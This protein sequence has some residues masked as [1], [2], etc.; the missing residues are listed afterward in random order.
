MIYIIRNTRL[1]EKM[2]NLAVVRQRFE[3]GLTPMTSYFLTQQ[4]GLK[5]IRGFDDQP[6]EKRSRDDL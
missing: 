4:S 2:Q 1:D 3:C 5:E 6:F